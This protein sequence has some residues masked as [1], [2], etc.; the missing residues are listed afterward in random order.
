MRS[1]TLHSGQHVTTVASCSSLSFRTSAAIRSC[2]ALVGVGL[3]FDGGH[4][5]NVLA[6]TRHFNRTCSLAEQFE[7]S[8]VTARLS[9]GDWGLSGFVL[10][11]FMTMNEVRE[12]GSMTASDI[13]AVRTSDSTPRGCV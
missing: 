3:F 6:R 5:A 9:V 10:Q 8:L 13:S 12:N 7:S 4:C 2:D 1:L 11:Y